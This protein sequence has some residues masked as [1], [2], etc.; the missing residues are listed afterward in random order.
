M[1]DTEKDLLNQVPFL[2]SESI[3]RGVTNVIPTPERGV[4]P[5]PP[6]RRKSSITNQWLDKIESSMKRTFKELLSLS[7][8]NAMAI[9]IETV[10][11]SNETKD[12]WI[13]T[14]IALIYFHIETLDSLQK[15]LLQ[16]L[17]KSANY[18][19]YFESGVVN[20]TDNI[21][22]QIR[23]HRWTLTTILAGTI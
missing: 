5:D 9:T 11:T 13:N 7:K 18:T 4:K 23:Q 20:K 8:V 22:K 1:K 17:S 12:N 3:Q 6:E 21:L 19:L 2:Q 10:G 14:F 15:L 16:I